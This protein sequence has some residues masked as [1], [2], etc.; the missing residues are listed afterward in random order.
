MIEMLALPEGDT[1]KFIAEKAKVEF[2]SFS[3]QAGKGNF[4]NARRRAF[5]IW[6]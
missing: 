4:Q 6:S 2:N 3:Q 1:E 5:S